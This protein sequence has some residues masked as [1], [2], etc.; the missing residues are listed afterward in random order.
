MEIENI[1]R[2]HPSHALIALA[3]D[4]QDELQEGD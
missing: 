2:E 1:P 4:I 3:M